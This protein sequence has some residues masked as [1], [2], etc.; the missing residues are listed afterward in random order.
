M[1]R[2]WHY[3]RESLSAL[4]PEA[5]QWSVP[6]EHDTSLKWSRPKTGQTLTTRRKSPDAARS[7]ACS[8]YLCSIVPSAISHFAHS[9]LYLCVYIYINMTDAQME[10]FWPRER[11]R[12]LCLPTGG[13]RRLRRRRWLFHDDFYQ[14]FEKDLDGHRLGHKRSIKWGFTT[15]PCRKTANYDKF[16]RA[17][18]KMLQIWWFSG[19]F[20]L[21]KIVTSLQIAWLGRARSGGCKLA[22]TKQGCLCR[23]RGT[24]IITPNSACKTRWQNRKNSTNV[25]MK[26]IDTL[27]V[28]DQTK[29]LVFGMI[30]VKVSLQPTGKVWS[31]WTSWGYIYI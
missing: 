31:T 27:G 3:R 13:D 16:W 26:Q 20:Q 1:Q 19:S 10:S 2:K 15:S 12:H 9:S 14:P 18:G 6:L 11:L 30:H 21:P 24:R 8:L 25:R 23:F 29:W 17:G 7:R 28:Q 22:S 5:S 4:A